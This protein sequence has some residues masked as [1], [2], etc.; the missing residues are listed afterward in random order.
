MTLTVPGEFAA[1]DRTPPDE[2]RTRALGR[3]LFEYMQ[4]G[5][6]PLRRGWWDD[7]LMALTMS[8]AATKV[9]LFR[10]I[11]ALPML[12]SPATVRRHLEEYLDE[13]G[14]GV[15]T[16]LRLPLNIL[17]RNA[18]GDKA[19]AGIAH[20]AAT[21]MAWKFIAGSTPAEAFK[22]IKSLRDRRLGFTADLLGEAVISDAEADAYRQ[23]C[24]ELLRG[25]AGRLA[26]EPEVPLIDRDARGP[27]PRANLSLKLTSLTPWFDPLH[28]EATTARVLA[29]LRSIL[30]V[31]REVGAFVNVD[32]EQ[33]AFKDL[34][35]AIFRDV[36]F[37]PEF[38]DWTDVGI[39]CQAYLP[40]AH[41]DLEMLLDWV[42][43]R[44][45]PISIRLVKG[46]YWDYEVLHARQVGWP[47]PVYLEKWATDANYERCARFLIEHRA[48][49]RPALGSHN[50]RS[51]AHALAFAEARGAALGELE[52]QVLHGMGEPLAQALASRGVRVRVYTPYGAM[53]PG[54]AYLVR[55]LLENTSNESFLKASTV[56]RLRW[57]ELLRNPEESGLMF[58]RSK[59]AA[60]RA[61]APPLTLPPF[62][63]EPP[64]DFSR[65]DNRHKMSAELENVLTQITT[66]GKNPV[67]MPTIGGR[68]VATDDLVKTVDPSDK[69]R[70][71]AVTHMARVEDANAA[72]AAARAAF[73]GWSQTPAR[74]RAEVLLRAA[75]LMR[76]D[77]FALAAWE[78]YEC[79]KPWREADGDV[80]EAIDFCEFYAR[81]MIDLAA[82]R[83]R[84]VPG[85]TNAIEHVARGVAVVL[86]PWNFPLA[87]P[88]GMTV[89]ALVAGNTVV[90]KP[91]EQSPMMARLLFHTLHAAGLP[92]GVLNYLPGR[93]A[94]VGHTLVNH[95]DVDLIAFTGSRAVGLLI[96]RE[97]A[98]AQPGQ[99]HVKRVIAEMGG[100]NAIIVDDDADLDEAVVGTL[101]S[102]FGYAG[103]KCSAASRVI[104][105]GGVY[106]AFLARLAEAARA[107]P[108]GPADNPETVVGPV[109]NERARERILEFIARGERAGKAVVTV[110]IGPLAEQG[111]F[112]G[113]RIFGDVDPTA[114]IAQDEIFGPVLAVLRVADIDEALRVANGTAYAL[115][116]GLYS[117]SPAHI[118]RVKQGFRVGNLYIN[119]PITG[120]L[121]DRQPF[122]GFKLSGIGSKA[123]GADY[124]L[125]FLLTRT[126]T[127]NTL[128]RGFAPEELT[129]NFNAAGSGV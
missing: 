24:I 27:I 41:N 18:F 32:M 87:I 45:T 75:E 40:E 105:L 29:R 77:R 13:A 61:S 21:R 7:R 31:A 72:V 63:N 65:S 115:T 42:G 62:Q 107:L 60:A 74:A 68:E 64:T 30:R 37:E 97:A 35:Y 81:R 69:T 118:E 119:R 91:A 114:S 52:I 127:E 53:L 6:G 129:E 106:D 86:P 20:F 126:V 121:V 128:R 9:Q 93:G 98:A 26:A 89:A 55:R 103:Q 116:G 85:E 10:F 36:M 79:G 124:L 56:G 3:A 1:A 25:V 84:D 70:V 92:V 96:N 90:L 58:G 57:D 120:A 113:P 59:R 100:K 50:V 110:D 111:T 48:G 51:V 82:L 101:Y 125:E 73:P 22:T 49:L 11:D 17:P 15:P 83:H 112:V 28:A 2:S 108:V 34:T 19:L 99:D 12:K 80:A 78:V 39:V 104:V 43:R 8:D 122:G 88:T 123:G 23:T 46:A 38:R 76:R 71:V 117:R 14:D 95:P 5:A 4:R 54:M 102:A 44:G 94:E 16:I 109:I 67:C 47:V 66:A 33:Y